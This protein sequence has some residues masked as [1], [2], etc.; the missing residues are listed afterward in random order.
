MSKKPGY[1]MPYMGSKN[2]IV[3]LIG[4]VLERHPDKHVFIDLFCGGFAVSHYVLEKRPNTLV[5]ANDKNKYT[6]A[7][8]KKVLY[9]GL[10]SKVYEFIDRTTFQ[11]ILSNPDNYEDWYVGYA[12]TLW[13]FG[14]NQKTYLYG[15]T[16]ESI[17]HSI[18]K[19]LVD[20]IWDETIKDIENEVPEE[21]KSMSYKENKEKRNMFMRYVK[22]YLKRQSDKESLEHLHNLARF[23]H[24][25]NLER[26]QS[27]EWS[28]SLKR[29]Q[30]LERLESLARLQ[31]LKLPKSLKQQQNLERLESLE[32]L[33]SLE[34]LENLELLESLDWQEFVNYI[35]PDILKN[36]VIYCDPPYENKGQYSEKDFSHEE[37]WQWFRDTPY[38]VYA[39][40]YEASED[41]KPLRSTYKRETLRNKGPS[42]K[43]KENIYWNGKGDPILTM[44]DLLVWLDW[45]EN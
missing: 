13:S 18:H 7:L 16:V 3:S 43:V 9:E 32:R 11:D 40:S 36:A 10:P 20:N 8:L 45:K 26:L 1:G 31:S 14:N 38:C 35:C 39:S 24:A 12:Q 6:I 42:K 29:L 27:L 34:R 28:K 22:D 2:G 37:F 25:V 15:K 5:L 23:Q 19:A 30:S 17:K 33:Q 41:I 44:E 4:D 21:I